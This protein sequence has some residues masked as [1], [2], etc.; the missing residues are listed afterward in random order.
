MIGQLLPRFQ[1]P[2]VRSWRQESAWSGW[3]NAR[4]HLPGALRSSP[5]CLLYSLP[6]QSPSR[7]KKVLHEYGHFLGLPDGLSDVRL[8]FHY[9]EVCPGSAQRPQCTFHRQP[10]IQ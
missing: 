10:I 5:A 4:T 7:I 2:D 9:R 6:R 8:N 1:N 3:Y